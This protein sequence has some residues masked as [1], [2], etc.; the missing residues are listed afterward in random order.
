MEEQERQGWGLR[1]S[2]SPGRSNL[3][4]RPRPTERLGPCVLEGSLVRLD[5]LREGH[6]VALLDATEK[7]DW[8]WFLV[9]LRTKADID[10]RISDGLR[11]EGNDEAYAFAVITK[12]DGRVVGSTSYLQVAAPHK[13]AEIG[14]TWYTSETQG[15]KVNPECKYLLL[16]H[17][18]EDWGAESVPNMQYSS[19]APNSKGS[20]EATKEGRMVQ[21]ATR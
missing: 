20:C 2:G 19:W 7:L 6:A 1:L 13:R 3:Q 17:A 14:S 9:P 21:C 16:R 15:T 11:A 5:P 4:D 18:F 10:K 8:G 12:K